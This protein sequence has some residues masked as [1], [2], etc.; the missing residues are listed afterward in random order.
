M[1]TFNIFIHFPTENLEEI[2]RSTEMLKSHNDEI[3][4][5]CIR[6]I[7]EKGANLFYFRPNLDKFIE[8]FTALNCLW[9]ED[10]YL[11]KENEYD[12]EKEYLA[13]NIDS[14]LRGIIEEEGQ[15]ETSLKL[16]DNCVYRLWRLE[17][18]TIEKKF[19]DILKHIT[20]RQLK[21]KETKHILININNLLHFQCKYFSVFKDCKN[22]AT[23][24]LPQFVNIPH[25]HSFEELE[26]WFKKNR[27]PRKYDFDDN[28][29]KQRKNAKNSRIKKDNKSPILNN[30]KHHIV[31]LLEEAI[32]DP[33][34]K[35]YLINYDEKN[36]QYVRYEFEDDT[37]QNQYH[38]YH[39]V[40]Q[41]TYERDEKEVNQI[42]DRVMQIIEYRNKNK[43]IK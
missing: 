15:D 33:S 42:P 6:T 12:Y 43:K 8:E 28:R 9:E 25:L 37:P 34:Y 10:K 3:I 7:C 32:G 19:P 14:N 36:G 18:D 22:N 38:G 26:R 30:D 41:G 21:S 13:L 23:A 1:D 17:N 4:M 16:E 40:L 31:K 35:D 2:F 11:Q 39:L 24:N 5:I 27:T 20:E 29:H